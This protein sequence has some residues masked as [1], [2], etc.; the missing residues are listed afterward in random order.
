MLRLRS[1]ASL[2]MTT[3]KDGLETG[4][5]LPPSELWWT[6]VLEK[7]ELGSRTPNQSSRIQMLR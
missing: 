2:R 1:F 3:F 7:R 4:L 6:E 5:S